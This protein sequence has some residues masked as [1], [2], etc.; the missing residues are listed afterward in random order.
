MTIAAAPGTDWFADSVWITWTAYAAAA[1]ILVMAARE[2]LRPRRLRSARASKDALP[3]SGGGQRKIDDE[4]P[5]L[6][7]QVSALR[8]EMI[9]FLDELAPHASPRRVNV[10]SHAVFPLRQGEVPSKIERRAAAERQR[11]IHS[12]YKARFSAKAID[13]AHALKAGGF[14][15]ARLEAALFTGKKTDQAVRLIIDRL[16]H[17]ANKIAVT[18]HMSRLGGYAS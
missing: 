8:E 2:F 5:T 9:S 6:D 17:V 11:R 15:D 14:K 7:S 16:S 3:D 10:A 12:E 18:R 13:L 4:E 1:A